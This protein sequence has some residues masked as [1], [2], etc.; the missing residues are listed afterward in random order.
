MDF[1]D[2]GFDEF[3]HSN[4]PEEVIM[5]IL[6]NFKDA[7][8]GIVIDQILQRL[9]ELLGQSKRLGK[10]LR[11]LEVLSKL[12]NLQ[13]E[14]II[15]LEAMSLVYDLETDIRFLQGTEKGIEIGTEKTKHAEKRLFVTNLITET[16]F[17][18][19]KIAKLAYVSIEFIEQI[20]KE[21][22]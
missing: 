7:T 21:L 8:P 10:Y 16:E 22:L 1:R 18:N 14:V 4:I 13:P 3:V 17:S 9:K 20:R 12:R 5:A 6:A 19:E 11:Q 15:K 2:F